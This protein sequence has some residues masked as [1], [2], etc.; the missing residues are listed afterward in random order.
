MNI[1]GIY[2]RNRIYISSENQE[3]IKH[4]KVVLAGAGLGSIIAEC[5]LRLGFENICLI[6]GDNVEAS[7]LNR[8]NYT[9][10]DIGKPKVEVLAERLKSINPN[11][12]IVCKNIFID[13][14]NIQSLIRG[15]NIAINAIDFNSTIPF[16]FDEVCLNQEI[17][18]I[19]PYNLGWAGCVFVVTQSSEKIDSIQKHHKG[20][21]VQFVNHVIKN[22]KQQKIDI[23]WLEDTLDRFLSEQEW[24]SP[25]QLSVASWITAG[26]C[27]D[28]MYKLATGGKPK[29]LPDYYFLSAM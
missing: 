9:L 10:R 20:F 3:K 26:L 7:N 19:H 8:Q 23:S 6:D 28:I 13:E 29:V 12:N 18:V 15:F 5:A 24:L 27:T 21:E 4:C 14:Q 2:D 25:P 22:L 11:A 17:P 1:S 16:L